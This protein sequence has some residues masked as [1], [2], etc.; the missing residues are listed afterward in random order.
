MQNSQLYQTV[1][2]RDEAYVQV[3][4]TLSLLNQANIQIN[5]LTG[6]IQQLSSVKQET[7]ELTQ[8]QQ[9]EIDNIIVELTKQQSEQAQLINEKEFELKNLKQM[10]NEITHS[11]IQLQNNIQQLNKQKQT[12]VDKIKL[13]NQEL[14]QSNTLLQEQVQ[15]YND[16]SIE[17]LLTQI[18][19]LQLVN[20]ELLHTNSILQDQVQQFV[21]N[22]EKL[23]E[24]D[25]Q[26]RNQLELISQDLMKSNQQNQNL[27]EQV[28]QLE[29]I[30]QND[31]SEIEKLEVRNQD[32]MQSNTS[33][34]EQVQQQKQINEKLTEQQIQQHAMQ[35]EE[36]ELAKQ[37]LIQVNQQLYEQVQ[38]LNLQ[39]ESVQQN[40][41]QENEE[42][43][44]SISLLHAQIQQQ[45]VNNLKQIEQLQQ[46]ENEINKLLQANN[47]LIQSNDH[48][49]KQVQEQQRLQEE[50]QTETEIN[51]E[52]KTQVQSLELTNQELK[53]YIE[54]LSNQLTIQQNKYTNLLSERDQAL[55]QVT[56]VN[57]NL[58]ISIQSLSS[59]ENA[60]LTIQN[61]LQE[62][63]LQLQTASNQNN[64]KELIIN[65]LLSEIDNL[66]QKLAEQESNLLQINS[67]IPLHSQQNAI[68][69]QKLNTAVLSNNNLQND[70]IQIKSQSE[71]QIKALKSQ[72]QRTQ[73]DNERLT[74]QNN[75]LKN[76]QK[77]N[78]IQ[79]NQQNV[80]IE[81]LNCITKEARKRHTEQINQ[82]TN[83]L[84]KTVQAQNSQ[85]DSLQQQINEYQKQNTQNRDQKEIIYLQIQLEDKNAQITELTKSNK[86][87]IQQMKKMNTIME[88]MQSNELEMHK[89][90]QSSQIRSLELSQS[91]NSDKQNTLQIAFDVNVKRINK[92]IIKEV[93]IIRRLIGLSFEKEEPIYARILISIIALKFAPNENVKKNLL[94]LLQK[95]DTDIINQ[96]EYVLEQ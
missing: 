37:E 29:L 54:T 52:L 14:F 9:Q 77:Q 46:N 38:Q 81:K 83:Q 91:L 55:N 59:N 18:N 51:T 76:D 67:S 36:F 44:Q 94:L 1:N 86:N 28:K 64:E 65:K 66:K 4:K 12:E 45:E 32:L 80:Q 42:L 43:I 78:A 11:N 30:Q 93:E 19:K 87:Y 56:L 17:Q 73:L 61:Q 72:I 50:Q 70:L 27:Q 49:Q 24:N 6:Q 57:Q 53:E 16:K 22:V 39:L 35:T 60:L 92:D 20:D 8:Q 95:V 33:L 26:E 63:Q 69:L 3:D 68:L 7:F 79:L 40:N 58:E 2:E 10:N 82:I 89:S 71:N 62:S 13:I 75:S 15:Q 48:L 5:T 85:I 25:K 21:L 41:K 96:V 31:K 23:Q 74:I 88:Q 47:E 84:Q 34:Q 90:L